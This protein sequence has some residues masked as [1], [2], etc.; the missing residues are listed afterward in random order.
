MSQYHF[1]KRL[2]FPDWSVLAAFWKIS[3]EQKCVFISG[4]SSIL[5]I[6]VYPRTTSTALSWLAL[7]CNKFWIWDVCL[8]LGSFLRIVLISHTHHLD[9]WFFSNF[10][11][12]YPECLQFCCGTNCLRVR[13]RS[14][15]KGKSQILGRVKDNA[16]L[17]ETLQIPKPIELIGFIC[18]IC[19][20]KP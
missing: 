13:I 7:L 10:F 16:W 3:W 12:D 11:K 15:V 19:S 8:L 4:L 2:F 1:M 14:W 18:I 20:N 6:H 9:L 17:C 5:L